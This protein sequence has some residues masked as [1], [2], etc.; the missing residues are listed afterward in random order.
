MGDA[1]SIPDALGMV[2][3]LRPRVPLDA[4]FDNNPFHLGHMLRQSHPALYQLRVQVNSSEE[5]NSTEKGQRYLT[6][7]E[8]S[9]LQEFHRVLQDTEVWVK[10]KGTFEPFRSIVPKHVLAIEGNSCCCYFTIRFISV[11]SQGCLRIL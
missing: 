7:L 1:K 4:D 9:D 10:G 5:G 2:A 3:P 11:V 6:F 8:V